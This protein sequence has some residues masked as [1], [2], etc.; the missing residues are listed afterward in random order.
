MLMPGLSKKPASEGMTIDSNGNIDGLYWLL[1][2]IDKKNTMCY[3][4]S[5]RKKIMKYYQIHHHH[6]V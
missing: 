2:L 1:K 6:S 5:G 4:I 3:K